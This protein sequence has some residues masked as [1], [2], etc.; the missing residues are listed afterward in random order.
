MNRFRFDLLHDVIEDREVME[1]EELVRSM[2]TPAYANNE[3]RKELLLKIMES[4][5]EVTFT[6]QRLRMDVGK[7]F[8]TIRRELGGGYNPDIHPNPFDT[9][10]P[11][12]GM[13]KSLQ[14]EIDE[15]FNELTKTLET[16]DE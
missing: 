5:D 7:D 9:P 3:Q 15:E 2:S 12:N 10:V 11:M 4:L 16:P 14:K 13:V 6:T 1:G 8:L